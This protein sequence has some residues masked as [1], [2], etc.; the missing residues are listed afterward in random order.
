MMLGEEGEKL[1]RA[2][3]QSV[4]IP[5]DLSLVIPD[6]DLESRGRGSIRSVERVS[7][8]SRARAS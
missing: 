1:G 3:L 4:H 5:S 7:R 6:N 8:A 2:C